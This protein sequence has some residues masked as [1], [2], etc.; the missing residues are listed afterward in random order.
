[1]RFTPSDTAP[2]ALQQ[3]HMT[4]QWLHL[5]RRHGQDWLALRR[6]LY[7]GEPVAALPQHNPA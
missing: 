3:A 6:A 4:A 5:E 2:A 1:V 7:A